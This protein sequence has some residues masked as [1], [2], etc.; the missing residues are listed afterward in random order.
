MQVLSPLV[1]QKIRESGIVS[2]VA[3]ATAEIQS[4]A[5]AVLYPHRG[6]DQKKKKE[7]C[8]CEPLAAAR[9]W[10]HHAGPGNLGEAPGASGTWLRWDHIPNISNNTFVWIKG[11]TQ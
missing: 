10:V 4:L 3:Q 7:E 11:S 1:A 2:A 8:R 6:C 9:G 5:H